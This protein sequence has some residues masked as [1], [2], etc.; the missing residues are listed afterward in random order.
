MSQNPDSDFV[1]RAP[2]FK[3]A[4]SS[5]AVVTITRA[6][7]NDQQS[8]VAE[9]VDVSQHGVKL[10]VPVNLVF[11]EALQLEIDVLGTELEYQGVASVRHIRALD[12][13]HWLV[14]CAIAPPMSDEAFSYLAT[15]AGK[16]RRR[17]RR[18]P[19]DA[20]ATVRRQAQT[21]GTIA[22]LHNL[23]SGGICFSS[24]VQYEV[25][26]RVQLTIEGTD[27]E[28]RVIEVRICWQV[29]NPDGSIAGCQF[30]SSN[31]YAEICSCLTEQPGHS[32]KALLVGEP[33]SKLVLTAA[34][35]AMFVPPMMTLMMQAKK[36]SAH[37]SVVP[38][39]PEMIEPLED[40]AAQNRELPTQI[41][42]LREWVDNT[43]K[44]RTLAEL[45]E[46]T[47]EYIMLK[48]S[49]GRQSKV[50]W[51]RLSKTDQAFARAWQVRQE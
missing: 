38:A 13:E 18:L 15:T 8:L 35:L 44:H 25:D 5:E 47:S 20:E 49:S 46:V 22:T 31:S 9:L 10:R 17:Y 41:A 48:K 51:S 50:P 11:E 21:E 42:P 43:G 29:D 26:E 40:E 3:V 30:S 34:V 12:D 19:I 1:P 6:E 23:S 14:G 33:T 36:V 2:R 4:D 45:V 32:S 24:D 39:A 28:P 27:G 37:A 16:E 7:E